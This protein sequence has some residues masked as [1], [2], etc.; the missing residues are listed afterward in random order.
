MSLREKSTCKDDAQE[1][2]NILSKS[3][4]FHA[5]SK[6][7]A[8]RDC[9]PSVRNNENAAVAGVVDE[10]SVLQ[11]WSQKFARGFHHVLQQY[12]RP[13]ISMFGECSSSAPSSSLYPN[14]K[15]TALLTKE[16]KPRPPEVFRWSG[17][18]EERALEILTTVLKDRTRS[19][20]LP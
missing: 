3:E 12:R 20:P 13:P 11:H 1:L 6:E 18:N 15:E 7:D 16:Q 4:T 10:Q 19:K 2:Q 8:K 14:S 17:I 9:A 5:G